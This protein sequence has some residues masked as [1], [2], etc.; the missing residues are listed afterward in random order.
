MGIAP[1]IADVRN[2]YGCFGGIRTWRAS[3]GLVC[4]NR[5]PTTA[6]GRLVQDS[7]DRTSFRPSYDFLGRSPNLRSQSAVLRTFEQAVGDVWKSTV[8]VFPPNVNYRL[9]W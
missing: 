8:Q 4:S 2:P 6:S 1:A 7:A 9:A 5:D 3:D